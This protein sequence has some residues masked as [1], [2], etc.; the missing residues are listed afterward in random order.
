VVQAR[1]PLSCHV[2]PTSFGQYQKGT[3]VF[4]LVFFSMPLV[5]FEWCLLSAAVGRLCPGC[6]YILCDFITQSLLRQ[7]CDVRLLTPC[8]GCLQANTFNQTHTLDALTANGPIP[9][10]NVYCMYG[11][12]LRTVKQIVFN[13]T[14]SNNIAPMPTRYGYGL[15][16]SVV[17]FDSLKLCDRYAN[18]A[19]LHLVST[20]S[21]PHW[22]CMRSCSTL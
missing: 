22:F 15:G 11:R 6:S 7:P 9:G 1:G 2:Y 13:V 21:R 5:S 14:L 4:E 17:P 18:F 16:D 19:E 12:H 10:V 20:A 3:Y 8:V